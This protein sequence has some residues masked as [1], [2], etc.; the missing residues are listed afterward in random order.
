M[1]L[2]IKERRRKQ[3]Q[4]ASSDAGFSQ[5]QIEGI[6]A[7]S[8]LTRK[9]EHVRELLLRGQAVIDGCTA[10]KVVSEDNTLFIL[11]RRLAALACLQCVWNAVNAAALPHVRR[12]NQC[13]QHQPRSARHLPLDPTCCRTRSKTRSA[14]TATTLA[15]TAQQQTTRTWQQSW[16]M[17]S[18]SHHLCHQCLGQAWQRAHPALHRR[19]NCRRRGQMSRSTLTF[20]GSHQPEVDR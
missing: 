12:L 4:F 17:L 7:R 14:L 13:W 11:E 20:V 18:H 10:H 6:V 1:I 19:R 9:L 15:A 16:T 2:D 3:D 5:Q 8:R